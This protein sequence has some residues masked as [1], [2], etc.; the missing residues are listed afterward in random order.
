MHPLLFALLYVILLAAY[1]AALLYSP[2]NR[3]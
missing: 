1:V 3:K 2:S